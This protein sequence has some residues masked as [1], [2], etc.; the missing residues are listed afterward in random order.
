MS[1]ELLRD[2]FAALPLAT[3]IKTLDRELKDGDPRRLLELSASLRDH[4]PLAYLSA[5][6]LANEWLGDGENREWFAQFLVKEEETAVDKVLKA[7]TEKAREALLAKKRSADT[8]H[9][10]LCATLVEA[11][12]VV[13]IL[14]LSSLCLLDRALKHNFLEARTQHVADIRK[15]CVDALKRGDLEPVT[16]D[17]LAH[18]RA[19][20]IPELR[21]AAK[22]AGIL[23][24]FDKRRKELAHQTIDVIGNAPKAVSQANAEELLAKRVY[25]D[26]GHFL[27]ELLQNA[28]DSGAKTWKLIF[29]ADR[30]VIW[31]NG[32]DFDARDVVGVCSIGQTTKRKDQIGFFGVGFKSV[33]EVTNRPQIFSD[34]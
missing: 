21:E 31:H 6:L 18:V 22:R 4:A 25:T 2:E 17:R 28:E 15:L 13:P 14:R 11:L 8:L 32:T 26:P 16:V 33:Y 20:A 24:Q 9:E 27:I 30:I 12:Q 29:D 7:L 5:K 10:H 19:E 34:G 23:E 1:K 3:Q